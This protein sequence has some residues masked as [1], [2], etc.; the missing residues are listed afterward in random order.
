VRALE[1]GTM[2]AARVGGAERVRAAASEAISV[3]L[4]ERTLLVRFAER[5]RVI[6]WAIVHGGLRSA[7]EVAWLQ[8][9]D[10]ELRPPVDARAYARER[11]RAAG[12][13]DA[14]ALL[15]SRRVCT[16]VDR[17]VASDDRAIYARAVATVGL[18]NALRAGDP[19]GPHARI[20]TIN[21]LCALSRPLCDEALLEA[22]ALAAE[23]RTL[24]IREARV[25]SRR[26]GLPAS[27]TGTD[28]IAIAAPQLGRAER[29]AGK[30][31]PLG[32]VIG[33]AVYEAVR[34]GAEDWLRER[35]SEEGAR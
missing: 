8:V 1:G 14:V 29:Y 26:S 31:T 16:Y 4:A 9:D 15:T 18:G 7:R 30:H 33:A 11:L 6:S 34:A 24:A 2:T 13:P 28:C 5:Q 35:A 32:F 17:T 3:T 22:L 25:P 23:A 27:G 21:V 19:P 12:V 10:R 20:G